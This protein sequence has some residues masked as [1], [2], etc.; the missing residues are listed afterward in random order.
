[1]SNRITL[2]HGT[3]KS[4]N[5]ILKFFYSDTI[6]ST[7]RSTIFGVWNACKLKVFDGHVHDKSICMKN[8][9]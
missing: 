7:C 4:L 3:D 9:Y 8:Q 2:F 6:S 1:M 5:F